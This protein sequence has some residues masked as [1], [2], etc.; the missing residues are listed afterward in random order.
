MSYI[1]RSE[2]LIYQQCMH[3]V[4]YASTFQSVL[5]SFML[6]FSTNI[7]TMFGRYAIFVSPEFP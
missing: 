1:F 6:T 5:S 4:G 3:K 2:P 7:C